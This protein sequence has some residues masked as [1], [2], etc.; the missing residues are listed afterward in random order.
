MNITKAWL[1][2]G[3]MAVVVTGLAIVGCDT[4]QTTDNVITITPASVSMTN[5]WGTAVFTASQVSSNAPLALPLIW[6]VSDSARGTIRASG[7]LTAIYE[8][9]ALGGNNTII[10]RDQGQNEGIAV[11]IGK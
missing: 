7:G 6:S 2:V 5:D 1:M 11:V 10:V 8:G 3:L 4:T 9:T